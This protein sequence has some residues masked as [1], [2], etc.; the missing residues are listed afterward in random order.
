M[1]KDKSVDDGLQEGDIVKIEGFRLNENSAKFK[2][3]YKVLRKGRKIARWECMEKVLNIDLDYPMSLHCSEEHILKYHNALISNNL[4]MIREFHISRIVDEK[5]DS[6]GEFQFKVEWSDWPRVYDTWESYENCR[7]NGMDC[8]S[9]FRRNRLLINGE[10]G[11]NFARK[12][13]SKY[14]KHNYSDEWRPFMDGI[15]NGS[16]HSNYAWS[17]FQKFSLIPAIESIADF[18][19][20]YGSILN[21]FVLKFHP[22]RV[23]G[24]EVSKHAYNHFIKKTD[25]LKSKH[26]KNCHVHIE[27]I[28]LLTYVKRE[29]ALDIEIRQKIEEKLKQEKIEKQQRLKRQKQR[30]QQQRQKR[31]KRKQKKQNGHKP[32]KSETKS[33]SISATPKNILQTKNTTKTTN[34][35]ISRKRKRR[36]SESE[37]ESENDSENDSNDNENID[38]SNK[39]NARS[40]RG[41][42]CS[43]NDQSDEDDI[44]VSTNSRLVMVQNG[45]ELESKSES[46][47]D[48]S[49]KPPRKRRRLSRSM[50]LSNIHTNNNCDTNSNYSTFSS[51]SNSNTNNNNSSNSN[52]NCNTNSNSNQKKGKKKRQTMAKLRENQYCHCG[53]KTKKIYK[54]EET[55]HYQYGVTSHTYF[56]CYCDDKFS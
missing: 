20:G 55:F 29:E 51:N 35:K 14:W 43:T 32:S 19:F 38:T 21:N 44:D 28:D 5:Q 27:C 25:Y 18:G 15:D 1:D 56:K 30:Q 49:S 39:E 41:N 54:E 12:F 46:E 6:D 42:S 26:F 13:D 11:T 4:S 8:V 52:S 31:R 10:N 16:D 22:K 23:Y 48:M 24:L 40:N 33:K 37:N 53:I 47:S 50:A 17:F 45:D 9:K 36:N 34:I 7:L 3:E 2:R